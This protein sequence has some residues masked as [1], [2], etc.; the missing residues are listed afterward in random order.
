[1]YKIMDDLKT[2]QC[3]FIIEEDNNHNFEIHKI[4]LIDHGA[5]VSNCACKVKIDNS[6]ETNFSKYKIV[7][8]SEIDAVKDM[9]E[10]EKDKVKS[11]KEEIREEKKKIKSLKKELKKRKK[12]NNRV[13]WIENE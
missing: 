5:G 12:S 2:G 10:I 8:D 1:M 9:I 6:Y 7:F 11:L 4:R 13:Y 3:A